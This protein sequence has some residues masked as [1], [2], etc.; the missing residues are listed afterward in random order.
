MMKFHVSGKTGMKK[1]V[2]WE[3]HTAKSDETVE[4]N[5]SMSG[6]DT[7]DTR[8]QLRSSEF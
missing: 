1:D 4:R 2:I 5:E 8:V 7:K 6:D 3:K